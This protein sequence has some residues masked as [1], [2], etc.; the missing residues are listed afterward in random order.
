MA[1]GNLFLGKARGS[2]GDVTFS[3]LNGSQI[4]RARA[5]SVKNPKTMPQLVQR[6][7]VATVMQAYSAGKAIFDHSFEGKSV[8]SGSMRQFLAKNIKALRSAIVADINDAAALID[9]TGRVV[10]PGATTPVPWTYRVSEGSLQQA[11]FTLAPDSQNV[12]KLTV[13]LPSPVSDQ[14]VAQYAAAHHLIAGDIYTLVAF[15]SFNTVLDSAEPLMA[16]QP[17]AFGFI[18]LTVKDGL[19]ENETA[20]LSATYGDL[21]DID[22]AGTPLP[23]STLVSA[24]LSIDQV[25]SS[26]TTGA[27]GVIRSREDSKLRSTC[28]LSVPTVMRWGIASNA[29]ID[30]WSTQAGLKG[31]SDLILEG[32]N[33]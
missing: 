19:S 25:V 3:V 9:C 31:V 6:A 10:A 23:A 33:F 22:T 11:L 14:T 24:V 16:Q 20:A 18:R 4:S 12:D 5:R 15:G 17:A 28:D 2:V 8:P 13:A 27:L 26:C 29:L 32:G 1:K 7:V 30:A 21:F